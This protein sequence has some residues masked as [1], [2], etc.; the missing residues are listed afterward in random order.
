M[1]NNSTTLN[2]TSESAS[3]NY[4]ITSDISEAPYIHDILAEALGHFGGNH[5]AQNLI[6]DA[7]NVINE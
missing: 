2:E 7:L 5:I 3:A 1:T 4:D 6:S